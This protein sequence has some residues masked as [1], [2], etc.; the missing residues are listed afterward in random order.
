M[1]DGRTRLAHQAEHTVNLK[2]G[3][4]VGVTVLRLRGERVRLRIYSGPRLL[5]TYESRLAPPS[6]QHVPPAAAR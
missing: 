6:G 1:K 3:A 2:T 4:V 5:Q